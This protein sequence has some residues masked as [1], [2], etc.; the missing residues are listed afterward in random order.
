MLDGFNR[1]TTKHHGLCRHCFHGISFLKN[2]SSTT[3]AKN[4]QILESPKNVVYSMWMTYLK[5]TFLTLLWAIHN[6]WEAIKRNVCYAFFLFGWVSR[7]FCY[8]I[9]LPLNP[10]IFQFETEKID[11]RSGESFANPW[12]TNTYLKHWE[13]WV[14]VGQKL[15]A[16]LGSGAY[17]R[18]FRCWR[19]ACTCSVEARAMWYMRRGWKRRALVRNEVTIKSPPPREEHKYERQKPQWGKKKP[20][21]WQCVTL[22]SNH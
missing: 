12:E 17:I 7:G 19:P 13:L 15:I 18:I 4:S 3:S 9:Y 8:V 22:W 5:N 6:H 16:W 11:M 21:R 1:T 20:H 2:A 10:S 14:D